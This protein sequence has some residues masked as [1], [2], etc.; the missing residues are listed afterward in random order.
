MLKDT[1]QFT[2]LLA[3][4]FVLEAVTRCVVIGCL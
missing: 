4:S 1:E 2:V 3:G